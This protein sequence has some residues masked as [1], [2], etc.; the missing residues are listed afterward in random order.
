MSSNTIS[1]LAPGM[2]SLASPLK[3]LYENVRLMRLGSR[4]R[5]SG[6]MPVR[7]LCEKSNAS[8]LVNPT[9]LLGNTPI[10]EFQLASNTVALPN[11][12][13]SHGKQ[14]TS[15]L[16][17]KTISLRVAPILPT[18]VGIHPP[19]L[20][21]ARTMTEAVELPK[22]SGIWELKRLSLRKMASSSLSKSSDG[23][24]PSKSLN[25]RSRYLRLGRPMTTMGK[26]PTKRLLLT[27]SSWRRARREKLFGMTPQKRLELIWKMAM[28]LRRPSSTG[29]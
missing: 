24:G 20:L 13:I 14:P 15:P 11:D 27:S 16:F 25:L 26:D 7:M 6:T 10:N 19:S 9:K 5:L 17:I 22:F 18:L 12:P 2:H 3:K 21:L 28:S 4:Q 23:M 8:T 1:D 29:R